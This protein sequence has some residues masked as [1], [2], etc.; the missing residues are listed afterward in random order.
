MEGNSG[1]LL[2]SAIFFLLWIFSP[3]VSE[4]LPNSDIQFV[5]VNFTRLSLVF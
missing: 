2:A 1:P 5:T 4:R 3:C